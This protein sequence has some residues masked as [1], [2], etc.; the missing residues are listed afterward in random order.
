[1]RPEAQIEVFIGLDVGK[2]AHHATLIGR[3]GEVLSTRATSN[4]QAALEALLRFAAEHGPAALVLDQP[5]SIAALTLAVCRQHGVPVAYV[6]GL[7]MRRAADLYPGEAKTDVRD[8]FVLADFARTHPD[9]LRWLEVT[10]ET[11]EELRLLS[12]YD[13]DLA[14]DRVRVVNRLRDL[15]T[16]LHPPL[17][18]LLG[19]RAHLASP[20]TA[21]A[22]NRRTPCRRR[23][24]RAERSDDHCAGG[25]TTRGDRRGTGE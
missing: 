14:D 5:G 1:M 3:N 17:E 2:T 15:L 16:S 8:S 24:R 11:L 12:G 18:A 6:P 10:D 13:D 23:R 25:A 21:R 19:P 7:V 22:S 20:P 9:N 4:D